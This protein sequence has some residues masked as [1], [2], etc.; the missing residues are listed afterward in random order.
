VRQQRGSSDSNIQHLYLKNLS[1][2][3]FIV[4]VGDNGQTSPTQSFV[5]TSSEST[6]I[7]SSCVVSAIQS[8]TKQLDLEKA[9]P[10]S[11]LN[12]EALQW[13]HIFWLI[14]V[15]FGLVLVI[16]R[17][18]VLL[19][20]ASFFQTK[21][22]FADVFGP[23]MFA[24]TTIKFPKGI[25]DYPNKSIYVLEHHNAVIESYLMQKIGRN[26]KVAY[27]AAEKLKNSLVFQLIGRRNC[28]KVLFKY[29]GEKLLDLY[30]NW[31]KSH[32]ND[33]FICLPQGSTSSEDCVTSFMPQLFEALE[34]DAN[35][36]AVG[37]KTNIYLPIHLRLASSSYLCD[38][39]WIL[40]LP[41]LDTA[42]D[43]SIIRSMSSFSSPMDAAL[44]TQQNV[45]SYFQKKCI[46]LNVFDKFAYVKKVQDGHGTELKITKLLQSC[47]SF[48][49]FMYYP[50]LLFHFVLQEMVVILFGAVL[51][52]I[53]FE[54]DRINILFRCAGL[55]ITVSSIL[56]YLFR[57][58]RPVWLDPSLKNN[59]YV[60]QR[61][62]SFPSAH[63]GFMAAILG[64]FV[65]ILLKDGATFPSV[66]SNPT[67]II[68][69]G[70]TIFT[71]ISRIILGMHHLIDVLVGWSLGI[72]SAGIWVFEIDEWFAEKSFL[73]PWT[74]TST[75]I[76]CSFLYGGF[77]ILCYKFVNMPNH[78]KRQY[79]I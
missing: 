41:R 9:F 31:R 4:S 61:D 57:I 36:V 27:V 13:F 8:D 70:L 44:Q 71:G 37:I 7:E 58:P 74:A 50:S 62:Y 68:F 28:H 49:N 69:L 6:N 63:S 53:N 14:Y 3:P 25:Y 1:M 20:W 73:N 40:F 10:I 60:Y 43:L 56:K 30:Q 32:P 5:E 55:I 23:L 47:K 64:G 76:A 45:A 24:K 12:W 16:S 42:M 51:M 67:S 33:S 38:F 66:L 26:V 39:F 46:N 75:V 79:F 65:C 59:W 2:N 77:L 54:P 22:G 21:A 78:L 29:R 11:R 72:V 34:P 15:P 18:L 19:V 48:Y 52:A 17:C 35:I